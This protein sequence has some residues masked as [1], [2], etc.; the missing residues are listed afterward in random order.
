MRKQTMAKRKATKK[1]QSKARGGMPRLEIEPGTPEGTPV[2]VN[3]IFGT[4]L[5]SNAPEVE[6]IKPQ[7]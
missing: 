4:T 3:I 7:R 6:V 2:T 1:V 5:G